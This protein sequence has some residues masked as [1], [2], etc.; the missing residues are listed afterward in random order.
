V[1]H[2]SGPTGAAVADEAGR[3]VVPLLVK[4]VERVLERGGRTA[5]VLGRQ[6]YEGVESIYLFRPGDC[7]RL[8]VFIHRRGH[9]LV[10]DRQI[11]IRDVDDLI[12]RVAALPGNGLDPVRYVQRLA[13]W[14]SASDDDAYLEH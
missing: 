10:Q 12:D 13:T 3:L 6:E 2:R 9:G 4:Q 11:K 1:L 5:V 7:V 8:A 14:T